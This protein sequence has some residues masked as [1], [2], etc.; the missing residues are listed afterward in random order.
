MKKIRDIKNIGNNNWIRFTAVFFVTVS[1]N[2][3]FLNMFPGNIYSDLAFVFAVLFILKLFGF[4]TVNIFLY[5]VFYLLLAS[6]VSLMDNYELQYR[7][8]DSISFYVPLFF[9]LSFVNY[10]YEYRI[11][12]KTGAGKR[13]N[14]YLYLFLVFAALFLFSAIF[15][16]QVDIK[17]H[18]FN[19]FLTDRYFREVDTID[20]GSK[21]VYNEMSF[22]IEYPGDYY[23]LEDYFNVS[24]RAVDESDVRGSR[25]DYIAIYADNEPGDGGRL[26]AGGDHGVGIFELRKSSEGH[27]F[28][29]K[30][31]SNRLDDGMG[32]IFVCFHS[33]NFGWKCEKIPVIVNNEGDVV[34]K[35]L[36]ELRDGEFVN[37][38]VSEDGEGI[39][40]DEGI[41]MLKSASFPV[42]IESGRDYLVSFKIR[43]LSNL[44]NRVF[45]DLMGNGYDDPEQEF[46]IGHEMIDESYRVVSRFINSGDVPEGVIYF[47]IFTY[48]GGSIKVNEPVIYEVEEQG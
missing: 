18:F 15:F 43:K 7:V 39:I 46:S 32:R 34:S 37:A 27:G 19:R 25:I 42:D 36:E 21:E 3:L 45:F 22:S 24:G 10:V 48:S 28:D 44:D 38:R 30:I 2:M 5:S 41:G 14:A 4:T 47:R 11:R 17:V 12:G 8:L 23:I 40:I 6:G 20:A 31:D 33:N 29:F 1:V 9:I 13:K 26:I 16:N 35:V